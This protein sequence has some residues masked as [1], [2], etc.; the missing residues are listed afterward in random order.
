M[1]PCA[2]GHLGCFF[3]CGAVPAPSCTLFLRCD[4]FQSLHPD[5]RVD[6]GV[7]RV[8]VVVGAFVDC[9]SRCFCPVFC[10]HC[11]NMKKPRRPLSLT[12]HAYK[13]KGCQQLVWLQPG[14]KHGCSSLVAFNG[15]NSLVASRM[16]T[17]R[18]ANEHICPATSLNNEKIRSNK[19]VQ[20]WAKNS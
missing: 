3:I 17:I 12:Q 6:F 9:S 8:H 5:R 4:V 16:S 13:N 11:W 2:G 1:S 7:I 10:R 20:K 15:C 18:L 19:W 14:E